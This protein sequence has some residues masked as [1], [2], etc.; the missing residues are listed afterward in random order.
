MQILD[1]LQC[2]SLFFTKP[3]AFTDTRAII[4]ANAGELCYFRIYETP[5]LISSIHPGFKYY[6]R[7]ARSRLAAAAQEQ[8]VSSNVNHSAFRKQAPAY[9]KTDSGDNH[10]KNQNR[11]SIHQTVSSSR[12]LP[13]HISRSGRLVF[14]NTA[15]S[16]CLINRLFD[17]KLNSGC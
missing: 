2:R 9:K 4:N 16:R 10:Q 15:S 11:F 1:H 14:D 12:H 8:L 7:H 5:G 6:G 17:E 3:V 13:G